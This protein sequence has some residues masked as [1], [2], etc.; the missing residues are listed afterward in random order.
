MGKRGREPA[1]GRR[2]ASRLGEMRA[3]GRILGNRDAQTVFEKGQASGRNLTIF[4]SLVL[5]V[6]VVITSTGCSTADSRA[7]SGG[8][9]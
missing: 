2:S 1:G 4:K 7:P 3:V 9:R 8:Y 5:A 6:L